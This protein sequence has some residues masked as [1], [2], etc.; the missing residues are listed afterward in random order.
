VIHGNYLTEDEI[1]FLGTQPQMSVVFC[2]RT[3]AYF[4]HENH[5]WRR[6]IDAG[7]NVALGTDGRSSNPDL[8]VWNEVLFLR[9]KYPDVAPQALLTIATMNGAKALGLPDTGSALAI[10]APAR[11]TIIRGLPDGTSDPF[12]AILHPE[13]TAHPLPA[14]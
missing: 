14:T 13:T 8:S 4:G 11:M 6:L 7:G 1:A 3:H 2:P 10:G 9:A 12:A 5:P